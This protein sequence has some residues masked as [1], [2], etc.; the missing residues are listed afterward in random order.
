MRQD[1]AG[2]AQAASTGRI[3]TRRGLLQQAGAAIVAAAFPSATCFAA[4]P[5]GRVMARLSSYMS[6]ARERSL[7]DDVV[8]KVKQHKIR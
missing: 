1:I 2:K 5:G 4:E 7:P 3:M 8:E 6:A